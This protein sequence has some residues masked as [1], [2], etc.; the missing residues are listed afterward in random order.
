MLI[1]VMGL[2][3]FFYVKLWFVRRL[4]F[5]YGERMLMLNM[6]TTL[7]EYDFLIVWM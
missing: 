1:V 3:V 6:L 2:Y 7:V 4:C 5:I